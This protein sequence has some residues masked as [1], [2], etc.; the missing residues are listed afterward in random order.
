MA[1]GPL[2]EGV[3]SLEVAL[4]ILI[5]VSATMVGAAGYL[6]ARM[7]TTEDEARANGLKKLNEA[8]TAWIAANQAIYLDQ[9]YFVQADVESFQGRVDNAR[10]LRSAMLA[11]QLGYFDQ[12]GNPATVFNGNNT[13]AW[14]SYYQYMYASYWGSKGDS[15]N[16]LAGAQRAGE[17][18]LDYLFSTVLLAIATMLGTVGMAAKTGKIRITFLTLG[19]IFLATSSG[20][21]IYIWAT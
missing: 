2:S 19:V 17:K 20:L 16:A 10:Y 12:D 14:E 4:T 21:I 3:K 6:S 18:S 11:V 1:T 8:N 5:A 15:D 13:A 7:H 9:Q